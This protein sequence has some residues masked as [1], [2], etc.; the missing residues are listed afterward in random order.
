MDDGP[1]PT[2]RH[3]SVR[4]AGEVVAGTGPAFRLVAT[5]LDG[6]LLRP[7][8]S[9]SKRTV[10][11]VRAARKAGIHVIAVT[12]R[13]PRATRDVALAAG[14][15]PL[16][17]CANGAAVVAAPSMEPLE[18]RPISAGMAKAL[19]TNL[20]LHFPG[21]LFAAELPEF[22]AYETGFFETGRLWEE[23]AQPVTDILEALARSALKLIVRQ[24]GASA[25]D[26]MAYLSQGHAGQM[27]VTSSGPNW[28]EIA[29]PGIS[30]AH[31]TLWVCERLGIDPSEVLAIGDYYNDL[32]L[33]AWAGAAAAPANALPEVLAAARQVIPP[34]DEDG[35]AQLL[36]DLAGVAMR[37]T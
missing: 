12:G 20:R 13:P 17:V 24:P 33:L 4:P 28:V 16:A 35:V 36:E 6:T 3:L 5:D 22:L 21:A 18:L 7:D 27:S 25:S 14:L 30:K 1:C 19:V 37:P 2:D 23:F 32:P 11:A 31:G 29:A 8:G 10:Q 15:G 26:L 34:N 9:V